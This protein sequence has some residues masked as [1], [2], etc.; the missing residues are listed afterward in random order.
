MN[1]RQYMAKYYRENKKR[2]MAQRARH[3]DEYREYQL[4]YRLAHKKPGS[5]YG[6][7]GK[8]NYV[9]RYRLRRYG[10]TQEEYDKL[11]S[12]NGDK[13]H[14]CKNT[15]NGKFDID[16]NHVTGIVRGFLCRRCNM[17]VGLC[18]EN[19]WILLAIIDYLHKQ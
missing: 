7:I 9:H 13:C 1:N 19:D 14:I 2:I 18:G 17:L 4:A 10:L 3:N 15:L 12:L 6:K 16:H 8:S 5:V 11:I